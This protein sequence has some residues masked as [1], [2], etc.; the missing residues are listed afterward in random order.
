MP[1]FKQYIANGT[2]GQSS[3]GNV[4]FKRFS[5]KQ[6]IAAE[7]P[8]LQAQTQP[9]AQ[10]AETQAIPHREVKSVYVTFGDIDRDIVYEVYVDGK[11]I[12][13]VLV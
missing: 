10:S 6:E 11:P 9:L 8:A 4:H 12:G 5:S 7:E 2:V 1:K 13:V 3:N